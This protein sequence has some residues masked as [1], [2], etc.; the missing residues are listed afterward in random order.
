MVVCPPPIILG[1]IGYIFNVRAE[2]MNLNFEYST[3]QLLFQEKT[4]HEFWVFYCSTLVP[5]EKKKKKEP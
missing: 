4:I 2:I 1:I 5:G 3:V